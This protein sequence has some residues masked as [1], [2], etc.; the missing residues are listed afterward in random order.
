VIVAL[1]IA[2][3]GCG[4]DVGT[5]FRT[6]GTVS[7]SLTFLFPKALMQGASSVQG[8]SPTDITNANKSLGS[9]YPGAKVAA[10][11]V[12]E[13]TGAQIT[14]PFKTEKDAFAFL[15]Q[16]ATLS[17]G[18]ATSG[19]NTGVDL[20][21]T[22]G[23]FTSA[24]HTT[25]G[26][27][28]TYTFKTQAQPLPSAS[29]DTQQVVSADELGSIFTITF[30]LTVPQEITSAPGAVFTLDRK[31]AIWKL[32][33]T[34]AQTLTATTA[35]GGLSGLAAGKVQ[36]QN[37]LLLAGVALVAIG[38]G[39]FLGLFTPW[40]RMSTQAVAAPAAPGGL[41]PV[42]PTPPA[43]EPPPGTPPSGGQGPPAGTPPPGG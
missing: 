37:P 28:D 5:T 15:T 17:P 7:V 31:T 12:G 21:N 39:F 27:T 24:T 22:G 38:L 14:I 18:G 34:Q 42:A 23:V 29:P 11:T 26:Q 40:R 1:L 43:P 20:S 6:D 9:K 16:A 41:A 13:E 30:T 36:A 19:S 35:S 8:F 3:V 25:S 32:S 2:G 10:V 4:Y 33:W